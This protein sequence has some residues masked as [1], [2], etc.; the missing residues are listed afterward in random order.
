MSQSANTTFVERGNRSLRS[1]AQ[2][3]GFSPL[4]ADRACELFEEMAAPWG[5]QP[6]GTSPV[7]LSDIGDDHTPFEFSVVLGGRPELRILLEPLGSPPSLITNRN[8]SLAVIAG[9]SREH[10][11][12]I[13]RLEAVADLFLPA[14]PSGLFSIWLAASLWPGRPPEF[15]VYLNPEAQ[16]R[17]KASLIIEEALVRLGLHGAY[18]TIAETIARRGPDLDELKYFSLD[19]SESKAARIKVY[20][21]HHSPT[22]ADLEEAATGAASYVAGDTTR[23]LAAM[24]GND[25]KLFDG[26]ALATCLAFTGAQSKASAATV[27]VPIKGYAENDQIIADR[28]GSYL[29]AEGVSKAAYLSGL[30]AFADGALDRGVGIQSNAS[31]RRQAG[32]AR[33]TVYLANELYQPGLPLSPPRRP[34]PKL[35]TEIVDRFESEPLTDHPLFARMKREPVSLEHLWLLCANAQIGIVDGFARRL[36]HA[37]ARTNDDRLR[38]LLAHQLHDELGE[39]HFERAHSKLFA[40]MME[41][42]SRW[43]PQQVSEATLAPGVATN[44]ALDAAYFVDD[45]YQGIGASI[46]AE[47]FGKQIDAFVGDQFRRQSLVDKASLAWLD[48]HE[49]LEIGH[50][51]EAMQMARMLPAE[52]TEL[53][54]RGAEN[55]W[56]A[57]NTFYNR[58]YRVVF[59][60]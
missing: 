38:S 27:Y 10:E 9:L 12:S 60:G 23:F 16:G 46:V 45:P 39:G 18:A 37:T 53:V 56:L 48:L 7:W 11:I 21:R 30:T 47:V 20:S 25:T 4:E 34:A 26:R 59:G 15:K 33:V 19:L 57:A 50:A 29:E 8:Q 55:V 28:V 2:T 52:S 13:Q 1:L 43:R 32:A 54:W 58:L 24:A 22:V 35:A 41:G 44:Q 51:E 36:A 5:N 3:Q 49:T 40:K 31:F 14:E 17:Q 42:L 6:I